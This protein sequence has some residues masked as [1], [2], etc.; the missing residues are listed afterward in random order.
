LC[1]DEVET[2]PS[3][4]RGNPVLEG[5]LN[6][7]LPGISSI[8]LIG[9]PGTGTSIMA[10]QHVVSALS[11]GKRVIFVLLDYVPQLAEK[12]FR[13]LGFNAEPFLL[14]GRLQIVDAYRLLRNT[15]GISTMTD[16]GNL[17][18]IALEEISQAIQTGLMSRIADNEEEPSSLVVDS[19][20]SLSP[21]ID[22][23]T[24]YELLADGFARI[25]K[26]RHP[27]LVVAHEGV[28]ESNFLQTLTRFVDGVIRLKMQ[29][30][31]PG[32][33]RELFIE[34]MRL[35]NVE[36]PSMDFTITDRGI[37]LNYESA[38]SS[39]TAPRH[40]SSPQSSQAK[41]PSSS[42][43]ER[44]STGIPALDTIL[45]GGFPRGT[46]I[47]VEGDVGTGTSTFCAQ[48]AWSRLLSGG[49]VAYYCI[50]EPPDMVI[51]QFQSFGWDITPY[52]ER[53]DIIISDG[54]D[55]FRVGRIASLKGTKE[56]DAIRRLIGEFMKEEDKKWSTSPSRGSP[57]VAVIDSFTTM[58]PYLD[59]KTAYVLARIVAD[60]ARIEEETYLTVVRSGSVEANLLYACLGTADG[61]I[62]LE[63]NWTR[64][65]P[66]SSGKRRLV[67][68][69]RIDKMAFTSTPANSIEYEITS[70]GIRLVS[71]NQS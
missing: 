57:L 25:R 56:P 20:T 46:F 22:V 35:T 41:S 29:R 71:T 42:K 64:G 18:P 38:Q 54:Y 19:F 47:C 6:G 60:N 31:S 33:T 34:K 62:A 59:L 7:E 43:Y 65:R 11:R 45:G 9:A 14:D 36:T 8:A 48:F 50:D 61:I 67:R 63:N 13:L 55:L 24:L 58:A 69:I 21:F 5:I 17:R 26:G 70:K 15:M 49:R 12:Y 39:A 3:V 37:N 4:K 28:L 40:L 52:V 44:T 27:S 23:H 1:P 30:S 2:Q 66:G 10:T 16:I 32:F 68:R 51:N 53:K